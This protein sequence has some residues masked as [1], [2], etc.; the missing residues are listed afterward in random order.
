MYGLQ[1]NLNTR[2]DTT[3]YAPQV[4]ATLARMS[5]REMNIEL[6]DALLRHI[7]GLNIPGA[8]LVFLPG[9]NW[10][11]MMQK[12][13]QQHP[14]FGAC[15]HLSVHSVYVRAG[16]Q[17]YLILPLHSQIPRH[18]QHRVFEATFDRR[19]VRCAHAHTFEHVQIILSTNIAETSVTID[20]VVFVIDSCK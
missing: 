8:I 19:K 15:P 6:M 13:L 18:E 17:Q 11:M 16:S 3:V 5:E 9:W 10:I 20:D 14:I 12:E 1:V 2:V 4:S 7:V